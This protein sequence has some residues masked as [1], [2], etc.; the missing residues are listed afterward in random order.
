MTLAAIP[1]NT[2]IT[3]LKKVKKSVAKGAKKAKASKKAK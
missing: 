3:S 2:F 1:I